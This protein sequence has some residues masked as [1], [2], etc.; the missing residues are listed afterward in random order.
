MRVTFLTAGELRRFASNSTL[1]Q[2]DRVRRPTVVLLGMN[3]PFAL[4]SDIEL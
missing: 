1:G 3:M 4:D 2:T